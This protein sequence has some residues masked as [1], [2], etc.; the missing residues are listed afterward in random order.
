MYE[1]PLKYRSGDSYMRDESYQQLEEEILDVLERHGPLESIDIQIKTFD[2]ERTECP[3]C[4]KEDDEYYK[5]GVKVRD[6]LRDLVDR[7]L[8]IADANWKYRVITD[9]G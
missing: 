7:N 6:N 8:V 3:E 2:G 4:G 5:H 1:I 9:D